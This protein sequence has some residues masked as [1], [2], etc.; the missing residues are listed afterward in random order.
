VHR[1]D[2]DVLDW[3]SE[4]SLP[5]VRVLVEQLLA[6]GELHHASARGMSFCTP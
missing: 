2:R 1:A 3:S 4:A 6:V 5:H